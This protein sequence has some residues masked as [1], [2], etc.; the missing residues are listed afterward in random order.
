MEKSIRYQKTIHCKDKSE[1]Q[2]ELAKYLAEVENGFVVED[3]V[4]TFKQFCEI[5][6]RDYGLKELALSIYS[7]YLGILESRILPYFGHFK[8]NKIRPIDIVQFYN[9]LEEDTQ[10]VRKK[11]NNG[12]KTR[13]PL[14]KKTIL[15]HQDFFMLCCQNQC[16]GKWLWLILQIEYNHL[17]HLNQ[18]ENVMM[19]YRQEF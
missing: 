13:K 19:K 14:S 4:L 16:I 9:L 12:K 10:I 8:L 11:N 17:K 18:N 6:K 1:A 2:T 7:R 15:E 5:W 3:S